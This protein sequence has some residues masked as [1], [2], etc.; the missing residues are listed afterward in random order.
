VAHDRQLERALLLLDVA[1]VLAS[2]ALAHV[3]RS[4][5]AALLPGL[6]PPVPLQ[7]QV[8]AL[9][10]F[11]PAWAWGAERLGLHRARTVLGPVLD[12][13]R[14]L[15]LTQAWGTVA[16]A[17][18]LTAAQISLNRSFITLFLVIS[19]GLLA[20]AK[21]AQSGWLQRRRGAALTLVVD[22]PPGEGIDELVRE[23]ERFSGRRIERVEK[24]DPSMLRRRLWAGGVDEVVL[25]GTLAADGL[26]ALLEVCEEVGVPALVRVRRVH[27]ALARPR[28]ELVGPA[29]YLAYRTHEPDRP[30]LLVKALLD[31]AVAALGL[32]LLLPLMAVL[33]L[34]VKATSP[35]PVFFVQQRAGLHGRPFA[36]RKFR[37]MRQGAETERAAL[38]E[39]NEMDGPVFKIRHDPR[40][41]RIGRLLRR[42]SLDELPQLLNVLAGEMSLVGPRPLPLVESQALAGT[43]RRRLSFK[44]GM[45]G[46]WQ[47]S[48]RSDLTF[49]E[50]MVLD[51]QYV[52]NWSLGLDLAI[53]LRTFPAI[54][55]ARGAR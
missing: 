40:V 32:L 35:G 30:G 3:V 26:R 43:H 27:L 50:W 29:L 46:L 31:R 17:L 48:G 1:L 2:L 42:W 49:A 36:M 22:E 44:P 51:L 53:L 34:L 5:L 21:P 20:L 47:V 37:S 13:L 8:L 15:V 7:H 24:A 52:D 10:V 54:L 4:Y 45:T 9:A 55:L 12:Y 11:T 19:T 6:K 16:L 23:L 33:A 41:T 39:A 38:I 14:I 18:I 28:A 25:P